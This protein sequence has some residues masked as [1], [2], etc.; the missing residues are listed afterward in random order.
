MQAAASFLNWDDKVEKDKQRVRRIKTHKNIKEMPKPPTLQ[1]ILRTDGA[2][3]R[4]HTVLAQFLV[5]GKQLIPGIS[6][7]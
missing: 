4:A 7:K 6:I 5:N 2:G 3:P 1:L